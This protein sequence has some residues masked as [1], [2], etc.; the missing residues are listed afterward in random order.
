MYIYS[1]HDYIP[2]IWCMTLRPAKL[3]LVDYFSRAIWYQ[4][5][6]FD[7]IDIGGKGYVTVDDIKQV[8]VLLVCCVCVCVDMCA[9]YSNM[10]HTYMC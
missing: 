5:G 9:Y 1:C 4:M 7:H 6:D 8:R 2:N 10:W 3:L